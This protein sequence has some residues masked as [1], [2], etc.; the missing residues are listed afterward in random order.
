M[1]RNP[2]R[3]APLLVSAALVLSACSPG[4]ADPAPTATR[5][6]PP[7]PSAGS[8]SP[9][10]SA[11]P[12]DVA[13]ELSRLEERYDAV[14]GLYAV[15]TGSEAEV[16]HRADRRFAFASTYKALAAGAVLE[17]SSAAD[18]VQVIIYDAAELVPYSPVTE[19]HVDQG[20]TMAEIIDA[21]V[22]ESDNTAGNLLFDA[23][24]GPAGF[25]SALRAIGDGTTVSARYEPELNDVAPGDERDTS[26][27]RAL[28]DDLR[29]YTLGDVLDEAGRQV[30]VDA[31]RGSTTGNETIRAGVPDGW[32]VGNKTGTSGNGA[33][34]DIGVLWPPEGEP[35]VLAVLTQTDDPDVEPDDALL[36]EVTAVA[37]EALDG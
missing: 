8:S 35:I 11:L 10:Q 15:D 2:R 31:L 21:A 29:S 33:R 19:L 32:A 34:N 27:A 36:A 13:A 22:Q 18:L 4:A 17:R 28:A 12:A 30:L 23:L 16:A 7:T 20:M 37:V 9:T 6:A 26:T 1:H 3:L 5:S 14:V 25:E 24:D